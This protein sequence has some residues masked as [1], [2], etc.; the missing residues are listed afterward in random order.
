MLNFYY[1]RL[2]KMFANDKNYGKARD[3]CHFTGKYRGAAHSI[4]SLR[5]NVPNE[6]SLAFHNGSNCDYHFISKKFGQEFEG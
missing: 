2:L 5:F 6:I 1:Q 3:H 4:C